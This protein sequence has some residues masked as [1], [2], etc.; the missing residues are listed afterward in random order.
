M[1]MVLR[2]FFHK[3]KTQQ[4]SQTFETLPKV[5]V[6]IPLFNERMVAQRIVDTVV[7]FDYPRDQLNP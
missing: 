1:S 6:Q 2:W 5:T 4:T 3:N 7:K